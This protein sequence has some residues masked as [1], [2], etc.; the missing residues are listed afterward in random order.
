MGTEKHQMFHK[1][2]KI[3]SGKNDKARDMAGV[4]DDI[5][6]GKAI[7]GLG[8]KP[9]EE[10]PK[11]EKPEEPEEP[12]EPPAD[13]S[14]FKDT[15]LQIQSK[16]EE[17]SRDREKESQHKLETVVEKLR[18]RMEEMKANMKKKAELD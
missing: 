7:P 16:L 10:K 13:N 11:E 12:E 3:L 5:I 18:Q 15:I 2:K 8:K 6:N 1:M 4:L 14:K 17:R 9:K